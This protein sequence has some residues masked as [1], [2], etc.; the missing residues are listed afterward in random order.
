M[1]DLA[2]VDSESGSEKHGEEGPKKKL[3]RR[4]SLMA[5]KYLEFN[6]QLSSSDPLASRFW[7]CFK[8]PIT[9]LATCTF[10]LFTNLYV[11][12]GDPASFSQA[13]S[14]GTFIGDIY[15]GF[16]QPDEPPWVIARWVLMFI[17]AG[18]LAPNPLPG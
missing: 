10:T 1:P 3:K 12:Y 6:E 14:Y 18:K 13:K 11:Y 7:W 15:H 2:K 5:K 4:V 17:L 16:L 9:R 8:H